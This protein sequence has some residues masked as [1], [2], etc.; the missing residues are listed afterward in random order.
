MFISTLTRLISPER[1]VNSETSPAY[2]K[3]KGVFTMSSV[4]FRD[5]VIGHVF[6]KTI[7]KSFW[8]ADFFKRKQLQEPHYSK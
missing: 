5:D 1:K 3:L 8:E 4:L 2:P 6:Q 7:Q